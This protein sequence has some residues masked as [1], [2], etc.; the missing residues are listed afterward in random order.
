MMKCK[1]C[2]SIV[3]RGYKM[4]NPYPCNLG[5]HH[6]IYFT[7]CQNCGHIWDVK[8]EEEKRKEK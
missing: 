3:V 4:L 1:K 7:A 2:K 8:T 5:C 6:E